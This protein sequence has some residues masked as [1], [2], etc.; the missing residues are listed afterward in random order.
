MNIN[1]NK[2]WS[3]LL[4]DNGERPL[5]IGDTLVEFKKDESGNVTDE[6]AEFWIAIG[7]TVL[8]G[9]WGYILVNKFGF[10]ETFPVE[11]IGGPNA[12]LEIVPKALERIYHI[13]DELPWMDM[14]KVKEEEEF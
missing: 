8:D 3:M 6:P 10:T 12:R 1:S 13:K 9:G 2:I 11:D 5:E 7:D 14:R 4:E